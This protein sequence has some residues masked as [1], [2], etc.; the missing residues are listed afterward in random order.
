MKIKT[1]SKVLSLLWRYVYHLIAYKI[2]YLTIYFVFKRILAICHIIRGHFQQVPIDLGFHFQNYKH[3]LQYFGF[4][5]LN[6]VY[7]K[8]RYQESLFIFKFSFI[9]TMQSR[10]NTYYLRT[11]HFSAKC[12]YRF[13]ALIF[14]YTFKKTLWKSYVRFWKW[15]LKRTTQSAQNSFSRKSN[16]K[17]C[18]IFN[19]VSFVNAQGSVNIRLACLKVL[20]LI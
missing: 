3:F 13:L 20:L 7:A 16:L 17:F 8:K 18:I 14:L 15:N 2:L 6:T 4:Y 1:R 5:L 11:S 10:R 9:Q 12:Q 19:M